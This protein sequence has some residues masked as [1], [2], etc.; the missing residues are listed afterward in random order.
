MRSSA[1][2][3]TSSNLYS[4]H[5]FENMMRMKFAPYESALRGYMNSWPMQYSYTVATSVGGF[6]DKEN[7]RHFAATLMLEFGARLH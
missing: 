2:T 7:P 6:V 5:G 4:S 1:R 3:S